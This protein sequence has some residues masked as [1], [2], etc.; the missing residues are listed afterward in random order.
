[1]QKQDG[2]DLQAD[3]VVSVGSVMSIVK[4]S[5]AALPKKSK[6]G[7]GYANLCYKGA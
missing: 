1:M 3:D 5:I 2:M 7:G 6:T 4:V